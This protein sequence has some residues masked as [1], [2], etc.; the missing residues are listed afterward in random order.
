MEIKRLPPDVVNRIAAGEVVV[1]PVNVI[2]ELIENSLDAKAQSITVTVGN[3]GLDSIQ[4]VDD[5]TGFRKR[6]HSLACERFATSKLCS[7]DDLQVGKILS[8]GFRGEALAS[9]SLVGHVSIVSKCA[10]DGEETGFESCYMDGRILEGY[11]MPVPFKGESGTRI[12]V[13]DLFYNNPVRKKA[14]KSTA[15]EYKKI[16]DVVSKFAIAFPP[17]EF[18]VRKTGAANFDLIEEKADRSERIESLTGYS[19]DDLIIFSISRG[20]VSKLIPTPLIK[21]EVICLNPNAL[22]KSVSHTTSILLINGRLI[23]TTNSSLIKNLDSEI[24]SHFQCSKAGFIFVSLTLDAQ[25]LDIN[26]CPTKGKVI[27]S[28]QSAVERFITEEMISHIL[29]RRKVKVIKLNKIEFASSNMVSD[30]PSPKFIPPSQD[31]QPFKVRTCPRQ[32]FFCSQA[33]NL[34]PSQPFIELTLTQADVAPPA[35][36]LTATQPLMAISNCAEPSEL[37]KII[38]SLASSSYIDLDQN[39]RDFVFVGDTGK[40]FILCQYFT[41]LCVCHVEPLCRLLLRNF[42]LRHN[43]SLVSVESQIFDPDSLSNA[44]AFVKALLSDSQVPSVR[45][46]GRCGAFQLKKL[47][48]LIESKFDTETPTSD[49][50]VSV[51][52]DLVVDW[53]LE[54]EYGNNAR[55]CWDEIVRNK[56]LLSCV[57]IAKSPEP[58]QMINFENKNKTSLFQE[59][60]SLKDLYKEFERC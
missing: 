51:F 3:G 17:V 22:G 38:N 34:E 5:G 56:N 53:L 8:F 11:P 46:G 48:T 36:A 42:L 27:Y 15:T 41:R 47:M 24:C 32:N 43:F 25:D 30:K 60:I 2:K 16:L 1:R 37:E 10:S 14:F 21:A 49:E 19:R 20:E 4:V 28:N 50:S 59:V 44:P 23:D 6:D 29:E 18:R 58:P 39:P 57:N 33:D 7:A 45:G 9:M 55:I 31:S 35:L 52:T 54:T 40:G 26:V 12:I 13:D